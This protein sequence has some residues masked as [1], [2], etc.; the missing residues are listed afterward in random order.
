MS[1]VLTQKSFDSIFESISQNKNGKFFEKIRGNENF[2]LIPRSSRVIMDK[3]IL[4]ATLENKETTAPKTK[5]LK[6]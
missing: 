2:N 4:E 5:K 1:K 3:E 6:I